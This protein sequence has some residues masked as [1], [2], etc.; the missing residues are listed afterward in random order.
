MLSG[1]KLINTPQKGGGTNRH[2]FTPIGKRSRTISGDS[3]NHNNDPLDT[4][5]NRSIFRPIAQDPDLTT[6]SIDESTF[7]YTVDQIEAR[8]PRHNQEP[9]TAV[10]GRNQNRNKNSINNEFSSQ[11]RNFN[12]GLSS[13]NKNFINSGFSSI[14]E[15]EELIRHLDGENYKLKLNIV[16]MQRLLSGTPEEQRKLLAENISLQTETDRLKQ[17]IQRL[18]EIN[19]DH[20]SN[21]E[22]FTMQDSKLSQ[23]KSEFRTSLDEKNQELHHFQHQIEVLKEQLDESES[24]RHISSRAAD[25]VD[26]LNSSNQDLRETLRAQQ[27]T[28]EQLQHKIQKLE[29]Q[30][31][32]NEQL[33]HKIQNL[34]S[35]NDH[36]KSDLEQS[37]N[38]VNRLESS[39][40]NLNSQL[41]DTKLSNDTVSGIRGELKEKDKQLNEYANEVNYWKKKYETKKDEFEQA[42]SSETELFNAR[43][44][45]KALKIQLKNLQY[46][47]ELVMKNSAE[48]ESQLE[49]VTNQLHEK[50]MEVSRSLDN[51][52]YETKKFRKEIEM[53]EDVI[54]NKDQE[55][56][57]KGLGSSVN[58][59]HESQNRSLQTKNKFLN[60]EVKDL[61]ATI[62]LMKDELSGVSNS[63]S[64][65]I[66]RLQ[67]EI[68][69]R[70]HENDILSN[71]LNNINLELQSLQ[72]EISQ[73]ER[74]IQDL[75][76]ENRELQRQLNTDNHNQYDFANE[77][78][79]RLQASNERLEAE[80]RELYNKVSTLTTLIEKIQ[81]LLQVDHIDHLINEIQDLLFA[82]NELKNLVTKYH[83]K[84]E[85]LEQ[86]YSNF[87]Y[88]SDSKDIHISK[89]ES[90]LNTLQNELRNKEK[91]YTQDFQADE[92]SRLL[93]ITSDDEIK[94]RKL[95]FEIENLHKQYEL[96]INQ[97]RDQ[98][99]L[100]ET[101]YQFQKEL[102][103]TERTRSSGPSAIQTLLETQ[104]QDATRLSSELTKLLADSNTNKELIEQRLRDVEAEN[105][106]LLETTSLL[107]KN[108]NSTNRENK[109]LL[110][111][112]KELTLDLLKV[113][114]HCRK[115]ANKIN[116]LT[117]NQILNERIG[118][119]NIDE[120]I[121]KLNIDDTELIKAKSNNLYLQ[122]KIDSLSLL[123][124]GTNISL[125]KLAL[126]D[127]QLTYYKARLHDVNLKANDFQL[128]YMFA[129][130]AIKNSNLLI[131]DD[132]NKLA[133]CGIYPD[134]MN[135]RKG[136]KLTLKTLAQFVLAAVRIRRRFERSTR[137]NLKL[138]ELKSEIETAKI[139]LL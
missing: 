125:K 94:I 25:N 4:Y 34:E 110:K 86:R 14:K 64:S 73:S 114:S 50:E 127:N 105:I 84:S 102:S 90:T 95:E 130:N 38:I 9:V 29:A 71:K 17:E 35:D 52:F 47:S 8:E 138:M 97:Q 61:K 81:D 111:K 19:N 87:R 41:Q 66:N 115:L 44:E 59:A 28:N 1:K 131:K 79:A 124:N 113:T 85:E 63:N 126:Y 77:N 134:Y 119:L 53:L 18:Q 39:L 135:Q 5:T 15:Q 121:A 96:E 36:L 80:Q 83:S 108:E 120:K 139:V 57:E 6:H 133:Q 31:N 3:V 68:K 58:Y 104:L 26:T 117:N 101:Q 55:I 22:N 78:N 43:K 103:N 16:A 32:S 89:L 60:E 42:S 91:I 12:N 40:K 45:I 62:D 33:Q 122:K 24:K 27:N 72:M 75:R 20:L 56:K 116:E 65:E 88:D 118:R 48:R 100:L 10:P 13:Q 132:I 51:H 98:V 67:S 37:Q 70:D 109:A 30:Q 106:K 54:R 69:N 7:D 2:E 128:M 93:R 112:S 129:I 99:K 136:Q 49:S 74:I 46:E 107:E 92:Y 137:R 23:L 76:S 82:N 11:N 21:K 123:V